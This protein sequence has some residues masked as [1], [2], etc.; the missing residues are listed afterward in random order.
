MDAQVGRVRK[1][2]VD[3]GVARDTFV[4]FTADNGPEMSTPGH[5]FGLPG[6]K[7]SLTEGGIRMPSLLE[8]PAMIT[9]NRNVSWPGVSN[10]LLPTILEIFG[11]K[12]ST[13]WILDGVSLLPMIAAAAAGKPLPKRTK[14]IGHATMLPGDGWDSLN[15]RAG[16]PSFDSTY[17]VKDKGVHGANP[18]EQCSNKRCSNPGQGDSPI[19][20]QLAWTDDDYK[21]WVHLENRTAQSGSNVRGKKWWQCSSVNHGIGARDGCVYVYRLY[22]IAADPYETKELSAEQPA[23]L[24]KMTADLFAWY[25]SVLDSTAASGPNAEN[26]CRGKG[27]KPPAMPLPVL[28][29]TDDAEPAFRKVVSSAQLISPTPQV[30]TAGGGARAN[31]NGWIIAASDSISSVATHSLVAATKGT[32]AS[33]GIKSLPITKFIAVGLPTED[34][35]LASLAKAAGVQLSTKAGLEGYAL[36]IT[37]ESILVIANNAAGAFFGVQSVLQLAQQPSAVPT[38]RVDDWPD[39]PIRGAYMFGGPRDQTSSLSDILAWNKKLV[40]WMS[41]N[42]MNFAVVV[43]QLFYGEVPGFQ[44]NVTLAAAMRKQLQDLQAYMKARHVLFVPTLSCGSGGGPEY[45]NPALAE[46]EW[47]RNMSFTFKDDRAVASAKSTINKTLLNGDFSQLGAVG[48]PPIGWSFLSKNSDGKL[49]KQWQVVD[50]DGPP[51]SKTGRSIQCAMHKMSCSCHPG[52]AWRHTCKP[53]PQAP[54]ESANAVSPLVPVV[55]GSVLKLIIWAKLV[56]EDVVGGM[57]VQITMNSL[58]A[59]GHGDSRSGA[60]AYANI[61]LKPSKTFNASSWHEYSVGLTTAPNATHVQF[62]SRLQGPNSTA[63]WSL[64]GI[65]IEQLDNLLRN[66]IR[67]NVTDIEI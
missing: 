6:R 39:F 30:Y 23:L 66:V 17:I 3:Q 60:L 10:D 14:G 45:Y 67:T 41:S 51:G 61:A 4:V 40:D 63:T 59:N 46:G 56:K 25:T 52:G 9:R 8:W 13:G 28:A 15:G 7:R 5:T 34:K 24:T 18:P 31:I 50:N 38:C 48:Q 44:G 36:S 37:A 62:Y 43:N 35:A 19:Q 42:K 65:R 12:S 16:P 47:V 32:I 27:W 49:N 55:G 64:G 26:K 21:L 58:D 11:V 53:P 22:D 54:C 57:Y 2:L 33:G 29:K 20:Q 1:L